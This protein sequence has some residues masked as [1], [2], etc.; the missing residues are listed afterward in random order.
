MLAYPHTG[1]SAPPSSWPA[2]PLVGRLLLAVV[3]AAVA[4]VAAA[5]KD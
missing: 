3:A 1:A 5:I 4:V 2:A